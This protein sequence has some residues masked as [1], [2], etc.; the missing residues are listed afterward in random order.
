MK[1]PTID[2]EKTKIK[3]ENFLR[4]SIGNKKAVVGLSGGLDSSVVLKLCEDS[5]DR[6][7]IIGVMLPTRYNKRKDLEDAINLA[8]RL[9]IEYHV[10][11][12]D[13]I[14]DEFTKEFNVKDKISLGNVMA[15]IRMIALYSY[16]NKYN[17]IVVGTSNKSEIMIGYFTKYGDGG[18][19]VEPI[20]DI[21]KTHIRE[22]ARY[23]EIP[24][25]IIC[26][27][28][29]AGLWTGQT[30]EEEIGVNYETLDKILYS[31]ENGL[32]LKEFDI[33]K[34]KIIEGLINSSSHKRELP[35]TG[36]VVY[37]RR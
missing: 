19:D 17:G 24:E 26:K 34:V 23:L 27:K 9:G 37:V 22:L 3:I 12:I 20:G 35:P 33:E 31:I 4:E 11:N 16:S 1:L 21:Y 15:R 29:S 14:V 18:V 28:P 2:L 32:N 8:K 30:D 25:K 13:N 5:L 6:K 10:K 7:N 36:G